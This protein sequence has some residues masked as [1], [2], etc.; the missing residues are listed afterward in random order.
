MLLNFKSSHYVTVSITKTSQQVFICQLKCTR[1]PWSSY[2]DI[3]LFIISLLF[4]TFCKEIKKLLAQVNVFISSL[5]HRLN[6]KDTSE[7]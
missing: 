5:I 4:N 1:M 3:I 6:T 7:M 2:K